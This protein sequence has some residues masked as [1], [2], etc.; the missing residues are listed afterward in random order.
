MWP[1]TTVR[2]IGMGCMRL[3][4]ETDRDDTRSLDVLHAALDAGLTLLDTADVYCQDESEVGHNERL[5]ATALATWS[6]DRSRI[7]I[8]TKG[9]LTRPQG[10]WVADGRARHLMA[11]CEASLR[12]L[13]VERIALYQLHAPDPRTPFSTSVRALASLKRGGLID[14]IGLCNVTVGQIEEARRIADIACVQVELNPWRDD[15]VLS[16]VVKYC[17]D[18]G[19]RLI[20]HRPLGGPE[21]ARRVAADP[22]LANLAARHKATAA[23][24]ALAWLMDLSDAI[25]PIAGATRAETATSV[26]RAGGLQLTDEDRVV[27]DEHFPSGPILRRKSASLDDRR[28]H[29]GEGE[30]VLIMG[31]PG[32]G[33]TT[34]AQTFVAQGYARL[35]RDDGGGTLRGLLPAFSRLVESGASRI[36][37]D[38]T[39]VS[40]KSRA[41]IVRAAAQAGLSVRCVWLSTTVE[42]AQV[43]AASRTASKYGRLLDPEEM[44]RIA[45]DD[46]SAF[47]PGVQF[48]Y[49]REL[50]P[51][52]VSEGFSRVDVV[53]FERWRDS[54]WTQRAVLFWCDGVLVRSRSGLRA[55]ASSED[56]DV[57]AERADILRRYAEQGWLLLGVSWRP[58]IADGTNTA[59]QVDAVYARMQELL[60]VA[61][62]VQY[63][64]HAAGPPVCWCRKPLPG[65][66]VVFINRHRLAPSQCAYVGHGPQDSGFA[67]RL[68][69][70]Y[71]DADDFFA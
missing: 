17:I 51:P 16:G 11:A 45:K 63:C 22:V 65:L 21:R 52:Q 27:L 55:P 26:V 37:L 35:N 36:V 69:F 40:R 67:R 32:A 30:V 18:N 28:A 31:L 61:I 43:N 7:L 54:S 47:G 53:P 6:G 38:N 3:S 33:K 62:D 1:F 8:A 23:E 57:F 5:I 10:R 19:I 70:A 48:R 34:A 71:R 56:V 4:T 9:G 2:P 39:Y 12:A 59:Q 29:R 15:N 49:Q 13:Q 58:D 25:V 20:A 41:P 46:V 68:G 60:G 66:G 50:E 44:R 64:P 42:D 24:I 14:H